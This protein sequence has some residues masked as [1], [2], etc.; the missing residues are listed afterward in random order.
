MCLEKGS[1][2]RSAGPYLVQTLRPPGLLPP[3]PARGSL[4]IIILACTIEYSR[5]HLT[6][7]GAEAQTIVE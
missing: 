2:K 7:E 1:N 4:F 5:F 3:V 6:E